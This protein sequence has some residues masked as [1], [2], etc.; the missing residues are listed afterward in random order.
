MNIHFVSSGT[1]FP[2]SYY[3]GVMSALA[4]QSLPIKLWHVEESDSKYWKII[5]NYAETS[6]KIEIC[7]IDKATIPKYFYTLPTESEKYT[8]IF[9]YTIWN[10][11]YREGG[12]LMELDS[13]TFKDWSQYLED[14]KEMLIPRATS[15][16]NVDFHM[17]GIIARK[18]SPLVKEITEIIDFNIF[19]EAVKWGDFGM[20]PYLY[21]VCQN[22]DKISVLDMNKSTVRKVDGN[23]DNI[24]G[25]STFENENEILYT[26]YY[27]TSQNNADERFLTEKN[28]EVSKDF[29]SKYSRATINPEILYPSVIEQEK[30]LPMIVDKYLPNS[31]A[32]QKMRFHIMGLPHTKTNKS[33][34]ACAYTM[35]VYNFCKMMMSLGH[36][37][38]HYGSEGSSPDCTE[39]I[40]LLSQEEFDNFFGKEDTETRKLFQLQWSNDVDYWK[41]FIDRFEAEAMKRVKRKDIIC[42]TAGRL[43]HE[44]SDRI[45]AATGAA[46]I[47]TG[48]GYSGTFANYKVYESYS[49][50]HQLYG[51]QNYGPDGDNYDTVIPNYFDPNDFEYQEEKQD[52]HFFI[53]R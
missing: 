46:I 42:I 48:I 32:P 41:L 52:Y 51:Y 2:Y 5:K 39:Q 6:S 53:G 7:K 20:T 25:L 16:I 44:V 43:Y 27:S 45:T 34:N 3:L 24:L 15:F 50:M 33:Y 29:I 10:I 36:E 22:L 31:Y 30:D 1:K 11:L 35:K 38:Y 26:P 14:D 21:V 40:D 13:F 18:G 28:I 47:E 49:H 4:N 12:V 19:N 8:A 17:C 23:L 9:D 37:V